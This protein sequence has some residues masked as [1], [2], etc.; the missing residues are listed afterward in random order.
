MHFL[1]YVRFFCR[2]KGEDGP[3]LYQVLSPQ[4]QVQVQVPKP[5]VRVQ[6]Q[7]LRPQVQVQVQVLKPQV[8]VQV[9]VPLFSPQLPQ[10]HIKYAIANVRKH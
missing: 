4:A 8:R 2:S 1:P 10:V 9:Q 7:V 6:V 5:Q 3:D